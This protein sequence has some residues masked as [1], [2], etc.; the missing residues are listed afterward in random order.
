[1]QTER[2][3]V[4]VL[5]FGLTWPRGTTSERLVGL[6][7]C[8]VIVVVVVVVVVGGSFREGEPRGEPR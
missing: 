1:M 7:A 2:V 4:R 3:L 5:S 8:V 6:A